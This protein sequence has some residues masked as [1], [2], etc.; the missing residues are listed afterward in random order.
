MMIHQSFENLMHDF[1]ETVLGAGG[2]DAFFAS[3]SQT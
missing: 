3:A 2:T 1:C